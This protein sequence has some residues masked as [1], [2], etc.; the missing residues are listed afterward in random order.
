LVNISRISHL[1]TR[2]NPFEYHLIGQRWIKKK[3]FGIIPGNSRDE[4]SRYFLLPLVTAIC[5]WANGWKFFR[6]RTC[7]LAGL[8]F[9]WPCN[10][11]SIEPYRVNDD[12]G[13]VVATAE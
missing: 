11:F 6:I 5:A 1:E 7:I 2:P 12:I 3:H 10:K 8:T 13:I 4:R 9:E